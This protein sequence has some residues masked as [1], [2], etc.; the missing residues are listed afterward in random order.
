MALSRKLIDEHRSELKRLDIRFR[1]NKLKK[2]VDMLGL[3]QNRK[4][5]ENI[6]VDLKTRLSYYRTYFQ[7]AVIAFIFTAIL[8]VSIV[9]MV[10]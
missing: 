5:I 7:L 6:S 4:E 1:D 10:Q 9:L 3:F 8:G 2:T